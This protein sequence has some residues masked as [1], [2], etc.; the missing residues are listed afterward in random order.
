MRR[1]VSFAGVLLTFLAAPAAFAQGADHTPL[2]PV[3]AMARPIAPGQ[4]VP[5]FNGKDLTGWYTFLPSRGVDSDPDQIVTVK[6]GVIRI[7]GQ[8]FGYIATVSD[9]ANYH[10]SF[11]VK[12]G[13]KRWPPRENAP[14]DS[15]CLVHAVGPDMVWIRSFECQIQEND[16]GDIFHVGGISSV[17][18]DKRQNGRV[19]RTANHEKPHGEWNTVEVICESDTITNVV[20]GFVVNRA[21]NVT[22]GPDGTGGKLNFGK[23]VFQ[24]EGAE[25]YYRNIVLRPLPFPQPLAPPPAAAEPQKGG[26]INITLPFVELRFT[27][28]SHNS[29]A[30][31][32]VG[33]TVGGRPSGP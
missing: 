16:F 12:W 20:N 4:E 31:P 29:D 6:D 11:E 18:D 26:M 2:S 13:E 24:S 19:I 3:P 23:I 7:S 32:A 21:M 33:G 9:Y 25:V 1:P 28:P 15:G 8:E 10:L 14:R 30:S 22:R 27:W 5:L 17:V